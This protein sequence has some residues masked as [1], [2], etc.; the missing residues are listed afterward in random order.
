[1]EDK[2]KDALREEMRQ[3][4]KKRLQEVEGEAAAPRIRRLSVGQWLAAASVALLL[5]VASWYW[6]AAPAV[7]AS[8]IA[9]SMFEPLPNVLAPD[10]R[11]TTAESDLQSAM[12]AYQAGQYPLAISSLQQL[13]DSLQSAEVQLYIATAMLADNKA[14]TAAELLKS[15]PPEAATQWYLCLAYLQTGN[16]DKAIELA[17]QLR[18]SNDTFYKERADELLRAL[19]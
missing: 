7:Q 14:G 3:R 1:M 2:L 10:L 19:Q 13:P 9:Q 5:G 15:L 18:Q 8:A 11:G 4:M 6:L 17:E 16:E 12:Q